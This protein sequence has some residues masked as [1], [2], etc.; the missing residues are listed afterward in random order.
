MG[1]R[2][3]V[4]YNLIPVKEGFISRCITNE[5]MTAFG[6]TKTS[7]GNNLIKSMQEYLEIYPNR[8]SE[9]FNTLT[10]V[11]PQK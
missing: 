7:A 1:T 10:K 8:Q 11:F 6:A 4:S 5:K 3:M 9:I 2:L